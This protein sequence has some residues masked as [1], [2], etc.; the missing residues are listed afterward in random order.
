MKTISKI[1]LVAALA[2]T[3]L[4]TAAVAKDL[5]DGPWAKERF[6]I[7]ARAIGVIADGD[8]TVTGTTLKTDVGNYI[9]PE[10][11]VTYFFTENVAAELIAAT[12]KHE[13]KAGGGEIGDAWILPPTLTLQYHFQPD[14]KFS[15]YVGAGINYSL[16]YSEDGKNGYSD[17]EVD[18]GFGYALQAGADYWLNDHWGLNID[19]KYVN[20][21]VDVDVNSGSTALA[22]DDVD[23]NPWILG[24]GVSYR[25]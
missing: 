22:A 13:I 21:E 8:G 24:A 14:A 6:Q 4:S 18:G 23:L 9:T 7:R 1:A 12:S 3:A 16:F 20:L 19:A 5:G 17:L 10:V 15:P 2:S 11:D 25:F